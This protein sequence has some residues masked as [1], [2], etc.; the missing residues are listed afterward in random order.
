MWHCSTLRAQ[1]GALCAVHAINTLLQGPWITE[2]ELA[3]VREMQP[4]SAVLP[5]ADHFHAS[6][7]TFSSLS[8]LAMQALSCKAST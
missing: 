2:V 1:V 3:Q 6:F 4:C 7:Q 8:S 5:R